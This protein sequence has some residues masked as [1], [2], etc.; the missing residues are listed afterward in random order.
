MLYGNVCN[1]M[2]VPYPTAMIASANL[3][4]WKTR[5]HLSRCSVCLLYW[6]K[7]TN[8]DA[9]GAASTYP[10]IIHDSVVEVHA[11]P[12]PAASRAEA[13]CAGGGQTP[14]TKAAHELAWFQKDRKRHVLAQMLA[15]LSSVGWCSVYLL[16]LL[17]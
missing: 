17:Y 2:L 10:H 12:P 14:Q 15:N 13:P 8:A 11:W 3:P 1:D 5:A 9:E 7:S 6:H 4:D 16:Y